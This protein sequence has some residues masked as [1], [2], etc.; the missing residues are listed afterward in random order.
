MLDVTP[1]SAFTDNY[2]WCLNRTGE[3]QAVIVDPGDAGPVVRHL[4]TLGLELAGI[5]ITHHHFDHTGG[6]DGLLAETNVP[7]YGPAN[8]A[9][10]QISQRFEE[11]DTVEILGVDWRILEVPG[12]TLDHIAFYSDA[13]QPP[14]LFCGDTLFAGGCGRVFEGNPAMMLGSLDKL[15]ALPVET[16]LYCA[17]EY[18]MANLAFAEAVEPD[19]PALRD[20]KR[21]D[22]ARRQDDL[23][24]VPSEISVELSTNPFLRCTQHSVAAQMAGRDGVD[25]D[26]PVAVFAAVRRWKDNF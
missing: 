4:E 2:I 21:R 18:T 9:I 8:P 20:R 17:H 10:P 3:K 19:N 25:P 24:T 6:I 13:P 12:H 7:V 23:P 5:I 11:G 14:V 22:S 15:A 26:D 1:I 16:R